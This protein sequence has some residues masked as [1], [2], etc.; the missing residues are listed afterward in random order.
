MRK[1]NP[2]ERRLLAIFGGMI[3]LLLNIVAVRGYLT[4]QH[5]LAAQVGQ[6]EETAAAFESLLEERPHWEARKQ[7]IQE[8]PLELHPGQE[9]ETQFAEEIQKTLTENGLN[10]DAQQ[11][12]EPLRAGQIVEAQMEFSVRGRLEQVIRWSNQIQ[13]PGN[14]IVIQSLTLRRP[15]GSEDLTAQVLVGKLFRVAGGVPTP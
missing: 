3:F 12:K 8:H 10:I 15:D 9:A 4:W 2:N 6:L 13:Q 11:M 1:P 14:H 7:W 5:S